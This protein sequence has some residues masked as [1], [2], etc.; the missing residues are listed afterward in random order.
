MEKYSHK[1]SLI[2]FLLSSIFIFRMFNPNIIK[3]CSSDGECLSSQFC[4]VSGVCVSKRED[5]T[6]WGCPAGETCINNLCY[7][8]GGPPAPT[9]HDGCS[10]HGL[11]LKCGTPDPAQFACKNSQGGCWGDW[12]GPVG[13]PT[14][15]TVT[16]ITPG[17]LITLNA[18]Q[19]AGASRRVTQTPGEPGGRVQGRRQL[20]PEPTPAA[21]CKP[22]IVQVS[23]MPGRWSSRIPVFPALR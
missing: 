12:P 1:F 11:I 19:T 6:V 8:S 22:K 18:R 23:S 4:S 10:P 16:L 5:C 2:I 3:A 7:G 21:R 9:V 17:L 14:G 20:K 13:Q 15:G